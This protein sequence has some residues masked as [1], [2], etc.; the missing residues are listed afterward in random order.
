VLGAINTT[1]ASTATTATT[2][3]STKLLVAL[4]TAASTEL[5]RLPMRRRADG[6][7][8]RVGSGRYRLAQTG[9]GSPPAATGQGEQTKLIREG[10]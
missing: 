9:Q 1:Y 8:E 10:G 4:G 2:V 5:H 7:I 6:K 3:T